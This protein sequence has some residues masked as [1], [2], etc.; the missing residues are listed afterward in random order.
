ML[1]A[2]YVCYSSLINFVYK[3]LFINEVHSENVDL[4]NE[5]SNNDKLLGL[6]D[7]AGEG[8]TILIQ[9]GTDLIHQEDVLIMLNEL[10]NA[11]AQ[12]ISVNDQRITNST[13]I[14]CDGGVI[15]IDGVKVGNPFTIKAIGDSETIY[16]AIMRTK[17]YIS[18]LTN[19]GIQIDV[20]KSENITIGKTNKNVYE[21]YINT[22]DITKKVFLG[23]QLIGK[24]DIS[25]SGIEIIIDTSNTKDITAINLIQIIN[26]LRVSNAKAISI[27]D[28]R[29]VNMTDLVDINKE[30]ILVDSMS[31]SSPYI[32]KAI[33]NRDEIIKNINLENSSISKL[34]ANG[35]NVKVFSRNVLTI[36]KYTVGRGQ[37]KLLLDY[38]K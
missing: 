8:I 37:N 25:G 38:L 6:T 15:L 5:L 16:G 14:Y 21:E 3:C 24:Y 18:V 27:N 34:Q 19:D 31:V 30:Y 26:D 12:A 2:R 1:A 9:D 28:H 11:G 4:N 36:P 13:Y 33:G 29:I 10:K 23:N 35:K 22:S 7:V 20:Q 32:I 17:G